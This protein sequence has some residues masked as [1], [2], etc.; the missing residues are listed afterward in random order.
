MSWERLPS[1]FFLS[2]EGFLLIFVCLFIQEI[3]QEKYGAQFFSVFM[4][5][6]EAPEPW[7]VAHPMQHSLLADSFVLP[8]H[9]VYSC[10][11]AVLI[12]FCEGVEQDT[13]A[14][15]LNLIVK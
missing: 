8:F 1:M 11:A 12:N 5:T 6:L 3:V 14:P 13:F 9:R 4:Q 15:Y 2:V 10:A 7:F